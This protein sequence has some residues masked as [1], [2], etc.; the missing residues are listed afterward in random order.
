M[1]VILNDHIDH[2]GERGDSVDVKPGFAR[3]YL[4]PKKLAYLDTPGNRKLFEQEQQRWQEMDLYRR[5]REARRGA[6]RFILHDGPPYANGN[7]HLGTALNKI[8]KDFIVKS[9]TMLG[10]LARYRPGW[11]CHGLPIEIK[12][13]KNLGDRKKGMP[14]IAIREECKKYALK[15]VDIQREQF[16]RLGV[17]GEWETP[18]LTL[19]PE[20]EGD[21]LRFLAAFFRQGNVYKGKK[22]VLWC[23]SCR[24]ALAEAEIGAMREDDR[25]IPWQD[26]IPPAITQALAP[27]RAELDEL[28]CPAMA[29]L[30]LMINER[31]GP[32]VE[33]L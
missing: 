11:D 2:I 29:A 31:H 30:E 22:P 20:Y 7:I 15:Y 32:A 27:Y 16:R 14:T 3:N 13:D 8:L 4:F 5:G 24:T 25:R 21:I 19:D 6:K 23:A 1:K 17:F 33:S 18:Y 28:Y 12:V 10:F 9:R 26:G